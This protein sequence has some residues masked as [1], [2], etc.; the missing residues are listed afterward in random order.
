MPA[1][2]TLNV[3]VHSSVLTFH[4]SGLFGLCSIIHNRFNIATKQAGI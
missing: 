4:S 2:D 1:A 3:A